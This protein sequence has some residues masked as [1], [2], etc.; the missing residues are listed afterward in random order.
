VQKAFTESVQGLGMDTIMKGETEV[1]RLHV[2]KAEMRGKLVEEARDQILALW[3]ETNASPSQRAAFTQLNVEDEELFTDELMQQHDEEIA[4]LQVRLDQMR[5]ILGMIEKREAVV[6]ER[7][8]YE[9]LQKDP[10]RLQ[11]RGGALTKQLMMEEKVRRAERGAARMC[12]CCRTSVA[13]G[14]LCRPPVE[15]S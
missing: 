4:V 1:R 7:T 6:S 14:L 15:R 5:P 2:L 10:E 3:E 11:Q 8:T 9:E 13:S 12:A